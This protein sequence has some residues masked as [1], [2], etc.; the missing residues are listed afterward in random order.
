MRARSRIAVVAGLLAAACP[1]AAGSFQVGDSGWHL[2]GMALGQLDGVAGSEIVIPHRT[3][4]GTWLLEAFNGQGQRLPGFP[5]VAGQEMNVSPALV[6]LDGDGKDEIL[7]I[8]GN[9][10][11]ALRPNGTELW[12]DNVT[13]DNY[14]PDR[15]FHY[16]PGPFYWSEGGTRARLPSSAAISSPVSPP[17]IADLDDDGK[18]EV[19][20]AWKI[21]PDTSGTGQDY[22]PFLND[23]FGLGE[24]GTLGETWS[25]GVMASDA[26]TGARK[27]IYHFHHLVESGLALG[28]LDGA[29][30]LPQVLV[31]NDADSVVAFHP[32]R[33]HGRWGEGSLHAQFGRNL[34]LMTG[35]YQIPIDLEAA[36]LD[37]DGRDE[38]LVAGTQQSTLW[39]PNETLLSSEGAVLWRRWLRPEL[40]SHVQGWLESAQLIPVNPDHDHRI[41]VLGY[42]HSSELSYRFWNGRELVAQAGWP[43]NFAPLF[44]TPP[45]VGDVDGDGLEEIVVGT[46]H[47][48]LAGADG[49]LLILGLDGRA[50]QKFPI[51]G[52]MKHPAVI[53]DVDGDGCPEIVTRSLKGLVEVRQLGART[54][55]ELSWPTDRG[56]M[57]RAGRRPWK[58]PGTPLISAR[59][60]GA[61]RAELE[62]S[63]PRPALRFRI[64]RAPNVDAPY[65]HV[66]TLP[67][68]ATQ[69]IDG[70]LENGRCYA[71]IIEAV[72]SDR[73]SK[74]P[75]FTVT[76]EA[77]G[78]LLRNGGFELDENGFWD[79]WFIGGVP[80]TNMVVTSQAQTGDRAMRIRF[81]GQ[82]HTGTISQQNQYGIPAP[83]MPVQAGTWYSFGGWLRGENMPAGATHFFE[84]DSAKTG[85]DT[86][87]R[88]ARPYPGYH[89]PVAA[90]RSGEWRYANRVFQLPEGFPNVE[91]WQVSDASAGLTGTLDL[92]N[93]VF[94]PLA[95]PTS[96]R[97]QALVPFGA[98][99]HFRASAAADGWQQPGYKETGWLGG[100]GKFGTGSGPTNIAT[101]LPAMRGTYQFRLEF[102][103]EKEIT[104]L[105]AGGLCVA[106]NN[107][108]NQQM[109]IYLNGT[110]LPGLVD[111]SSLQ[112]NVPGWFDLQPFAG[113]L[114]PGTN[115]LAVEL[116]NTWTTWDDVAFDFALLGQ[117]AKAWVAAGVQ[118]RRTPAG[119]E[120]WAQAASGTLW[121]LQGCASPLGQWS[122]LAEF[123]GNGGVPVKL[124]TEPATP[125]PRFFRLLPAQ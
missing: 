111:L 89:T 46:Y 66:V 71:Y 33:P 65:V 21:D 42:T 61:G 112:G 14:V 35:S 124:L 19:L 47:P 63:V 105:L 101:S 113:W 40:A 29:N 115:L 118:I 59:R 82:T 4:G 62:F 87:T 22:N 36:D 79:K 49:E 38:V 43:L 24:W 107:L 84:W 104:E 86:N 77:E 52:G 94:R 88:P 117:A 92:D 20:T 103:L 120:L 110:A 55:A 121:T 98:A 56:G 75:P 91:F 58:A 96:N 64:Y 25:G 69:F 8:Q 1:V 53:G 34:R 119:M 83:A 12:R 109:R 27:W 6:D 97:W 106:E 108:T 67:G 23:I 30:P 54:N 72:Y 45:V 17:L 3:S 37:G 116:A 76:P 73:S 60:G 26:A 48:K 57:M 74:S 2:G 41:D 32:E 50:K 114:R 10:L 16:Q 13:P 7:L 70:P 78:N 100:R 28:R 85:W 9:A 95:A 81:S 5:A 15:G 80:E 90:L 44:P 122:N 99:W 31:L 51:A 11:V 125:L 123:T 102:N 93:L 68:N 18:L 39:Q